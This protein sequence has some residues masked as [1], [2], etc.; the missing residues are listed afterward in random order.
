MHV[1]T[2]GWEMGRPSAGSA[3]PVEKE[4]NGVGQVHACMRDAVRRT[5]HVRPSSASSSRTS[6]ARAVHGASR[7]LL[8]YSISLCKPRYI[9]NR[10]MLSRLYYSAAVRVIDPPFL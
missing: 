1:R 3:L 7:L 4:Q 2:Q 10:C 8:F 5:R 9:L 6:R